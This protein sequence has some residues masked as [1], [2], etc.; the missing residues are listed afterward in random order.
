MSVA[1]GRSSRHAEQPGCLEAGDA[2]AVTVELSVGVCSLV[3][4]LAA[5]LGLGSAV[6]A[7]LQVMGAA[8]AG[9]RLLARGGTSADVSRFVDQAVGP[10]AHTGVAA[11]IDH[12]GWDLSVVSVS[13]PV[14]LPLPGRPT[15][16][17]RAAATALTEGVDAEEDLGPGA[18]ARAGAQ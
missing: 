17:V 1:G 3:I 15:I 5:L 12:E 11:S 10:E 14:R 13:R 8:S 16:I 6:V 4:V 7:Q 9:A 18:D 2:G